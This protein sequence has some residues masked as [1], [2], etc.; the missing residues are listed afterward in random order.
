[1]IWRTL[2]EDDRAKMLRDGKLEQPSEYSS[3][4]Y[5]ITQALIEDG[6]SNLLLGGPIAIDVP[7]RLLH[8]LNDRDVPHSISLRIQ[9]RLTAEDVVVQLIKDGDHR[10]S[11]P[12]DLER[13]C[14]SV[15][16]LLQLSA[17]SSA[18]SPAR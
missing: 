16:E 7:V 3:D 12:Q 14:A 11:R 17:A 13:L 15:E 4:P 1:L 10:L 18:A 5:V 2:S 9:E 8:G 6:R